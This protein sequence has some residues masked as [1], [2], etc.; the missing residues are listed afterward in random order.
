MAGTAVVLQLISLFFCCGKFL[1]KSDSDCERLTET[2]SRDQWCDHIVNLLASFEQFVAHSRGPYHALVTLQPSVLA[3]PLTPLTT[4]SGAHLQYG[5]T[6]L[7][8]SP[9]NVTLTVGKSERVYCV[10]PSGPVPTAVEWYNPQSQ[11]V[12]TDGRDEVNQ[13]DASGRAA[14]LNFQSYHPSQGGRYECRVTGPGN[15]LEKVSVCI[16]EC[17]T[18]PWGG[19]R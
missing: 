6:R 13:A 10:Q 16:G 17:Y 12:S 3:V 8:G 2:R 19:C 5:T 9:P 1:V 15:N 14:Y 18:G 7:N 4:V 11:L